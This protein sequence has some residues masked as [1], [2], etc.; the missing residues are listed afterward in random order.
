M[1]QS[2]I[3][4]L[5]SK[6][7]KYDPVTGV[8][9]S[10]NLRDRYMEKISANARRLRGNSNGSFQNALALQGRVD[11]R[12]QLIIRLGV[13]PIPIVGAPA[14]LSATILGDPSDRTLAT[15]PE[16]VTVS[17]GTAPQVFTAP[18]P[19]AVAVAFTTGDANNDQYVT[20]ADSNDPNAKGRAAVR[21]LP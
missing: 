14:S 2:A 21:I 12:E 18:N 13:I 15:T 17:G 8:L 1:P 3:D 20:A 19:P 5:Q 6:G 7:W 16:T 11:A 9:T 10:F 4:R